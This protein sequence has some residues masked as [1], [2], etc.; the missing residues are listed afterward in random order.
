MN[1]VICFG[2]ALIDFLQSGKA[3]IDGI[4][5]PEF[6]QFPGGA[7]A[8]AAVAVAKLGGKALFAGQVG[9]DPFGQFLIDALEHYG[10]DT[11]YT[12][13]HHIAKTA[14][15]F[16]SLDSEGER[17]FSFYRDNTADMVV[18][19]D[20]FPTSL[21]KTSDILHVCSNTLTSPSISE[22]TFLLVQRA[23][24][25]GALI[26]VDVNLRHNL[27]SEGTASA[28]L[29]NQLV[30]H[31]SIV[32]FSEEE[33]DFLCQQNSEAYLKA[34]LNNGQCK[35]VLVTNG[36]APVRY[37]TGAVQGRIKVP[38]VEVVD[39]TC[40]GDGFIGGLLYCLLRSGNLHDIANDS[41]LLEQILCFAIAC[42]AYTVAR[43]GAFPALPGAEDVVAQLPPTK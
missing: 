21:F 18:T 30:S 42:G 25:A 20:Q 8:N 34:L 37:F 11:Q 32:K 16:V 1:R 24:D 36:G 28:D 29:V 12:L 5:I 31:A 22:T 7:P 2:E 19:A 13:Q 3:S 43:Q 41:E 4:Q 6:R 15:A 27:W 35:L 38:E 26:S 9:R 23:I 40:G 39:T 17:S 33:F 14:M 10:V